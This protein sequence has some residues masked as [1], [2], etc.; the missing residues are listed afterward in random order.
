VVPRGRPAFFGCFSL[1]SGDPIAWGIAEEIGCVVVSVDYRLAPDHPFPAGL[2]DCYA[3]VKYISEHAEEFGIDPARIGVWG[4]SAGGNFAAPVF[5]L[6]RDR[7]GPKIAAQ[8]INY[9]CLTDELT[10]PSY[11]MYAEAPVTTASMDRGWSLYLGA[12]R[13]TSSGYAAPL[14]AAD[15]S[16][17]PPAHIHYAEID[18]LADDSVR[19]A[20]RLHEA[21]NVVVLRAAERMIHGYLRS[22]FSGPDAATE[23]RK[24]CIFLRNILFTR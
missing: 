20:K 21:G 18:C 8:A 14:K 6:A 7:K 1:D 3:A 11:A 16:H 23:F 12:G 22:R 19:Y 5:L 15:L 4:D 2:E 24:P 9:P 10:S 13:P 17:L